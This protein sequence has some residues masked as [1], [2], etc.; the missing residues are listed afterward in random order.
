M[1]PAKDKRRYRSHYVPLWYCVTCR[2]LV[3]RAEATHHA[4]TTRGC[5]LVP[6][7]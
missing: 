2:T 1:K 5:A 7:L 4:L 6:A 3:P